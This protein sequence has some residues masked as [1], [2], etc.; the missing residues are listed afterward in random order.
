MHQSQFL[1]PSKD[2]LLERE[3][4]QNQFPV[5]VNLENAVE[6]TRNSIL[7]HFLPVNLVRYLTSYGPYKFDE[8]FYSNDLILPDII[9]KESMRNRLQIE[10]KNHISSNIKT[11]MVGLYPV[12]VYTFNGDLIPPIRFPELQKFT[13]VDQYYLEPLLGIILFYYNACIFAISNACI[14]YVCVCC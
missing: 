1:C 6:D 2:L 8:V 11:L 13:N 5:L 7:L 3:V 14:F 10:I 9:W 12:T 4:Y